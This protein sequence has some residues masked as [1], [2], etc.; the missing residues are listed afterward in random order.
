MVD[1]RHALSTRPTRRTTSGRSGSSCSSTSAGWPYKK[2]AAVNWCPTCKTV[3]A[4]EQVIA[5]ACERCG[6]PVEQRFLEQWFFRSRDY[7]E[8]LLDNLERIDWSETHEDGAA[9][10][11]RPQRRRRARASSR[12]D[13]ADEPET[14]ADRSRC[15]RRGPTRSSA[16]RTWCSRP[17]IRWSTRITTADAARRGRRVPR[18]SARKQDLV[19]RRRSTRRR[20][21]S[22]PARYAINPATGEPIPIW[23]ADYVL[24]EYGTG[25]IMAVP[26]HD[27]RDFEFAQ[28][29]RPADRARRR[30][31]GRRRATRRSTEAFTDDDGGSW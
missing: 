22:S 8:R 29:V 21:A 12:S 7:A 9:Q 2:E 26:G 11:D 13:D 30:R 28:R 6:T 10:L 24:M 18:R 14:R 5:G 17:S 23:I 1:W 31:R 4:N 16:R 20:P 3:L 19:A 27:E 15:S 25:A